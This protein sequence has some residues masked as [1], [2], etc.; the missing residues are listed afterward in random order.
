MRQLVEHLVQQGEWIISALL[1]FVV[2]WNRFNTPPT[3]RSGTT[4][5]LFFSGVIFYYALTIALWILVII[6]LRQ[7]SI[8][9]D[10]IGLLANLNLKAQGEMDQYAPIVAALI[11][12]VASQF[13]QVRQIDTAARSFCTKLAAIPAKP[14]DLRSSLPK[15]P[16]F[17]RLASSLSIK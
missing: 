6:A 8:G 13:R 5:A 10:K 16:I 14:I 2:A 11:I 9:F 12:V 15:G 3:N 17:N 4:F 1:L 7:G